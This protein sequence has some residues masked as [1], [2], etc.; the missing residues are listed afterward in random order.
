MDIWKQRDLEK[1]P[2]E[3]KRWRTH[4]GSRRHEAHDAEMPY[5]LG[6]G[7]DEPK[8]AAFRNPSDGMIRLDPSL[9]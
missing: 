8:R 5:L 3:R 6:G 4:H 7:I 2:S 1:A 9:T